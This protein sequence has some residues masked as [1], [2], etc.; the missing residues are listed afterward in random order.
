LTD[1]ITRESTSDQHVLV[2]AGARGIGRVIA[3]SFLAQGYR[4]HVCDIEPRA[5]EE[6]LAE[7]PA[8][9]ASVCDVADAGQVQSMFERLQS[10]HGRLDV[11]VNNAGISGPVALA[12][13]ILPADWDRTIAV[14]LSS[15]FY[16]ARQAIPMIR[17][18]GGGSIIMI[19][20]SAAF[21]GCPLRSPYSASKWG[22]LGLVRTLAME[23]GPSGIRV[24][25]ICPGSVAGE[26]IEGVMRSEAESQSLDIAAVRERYLRQ[27]SMRVFIDPQD[28]ANMTLFLASPLGAK[29][30]G[31]A[32]G[33]DGHTE[34]FAL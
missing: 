25:A 2:T 11:L 28:V 21:Q 23:L 19:S 24:N 6:F 7:Y 30:S 9:S 32:L 22:L 5:V 29:V 12:E 27:N 20:S 13:D 3:A 8:A 17:S 15:H 1:F 14:D 10:D 26:R 18:Q 34:S 4:V 31:Q 16:C 33:L